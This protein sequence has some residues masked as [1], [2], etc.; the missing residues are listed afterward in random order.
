MNII[1]LFIARVP[2]AKFWAHWAAT[3][4]AFNIVLI[5][6]KIKQAL[7]IAIFAINIM[8]KTEITTFEVTHF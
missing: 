1:F 7:F 4:W 8:A 3:L 6:Y 5:I 2:V